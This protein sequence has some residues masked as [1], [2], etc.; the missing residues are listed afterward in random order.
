[1]TDVVLLADIFENFRTTCL[2][3]YKLDPC[4]FLTSP[5]LSW[6]AALKFTKVELELLSDVAMLYFIISCIRGGVSTISTRFSEANNK[7]MTNHDPTKESKF[8]TYLDANNL[9]GSAMSKK[10]PTHGFKWMTDTDLIDWED[11][12]CI[13]EVDLKYPRSLHQLHNLYP[14][15]PE[16]I[17]INKVD[18][19][20]PNLNDKKKYII[21]YEALKLYQSLGLID[22]N[23]DMRT[24]AT[25]NFE[26]DFYKLMNN[27]CYGKTL[28]NVFNRVDVRLVT[29]KEQ[30]SKLINKPNYN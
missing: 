16:S 10:L 2:D 27:S 9:Y 19:L 4:W 28:E 1:M 11:H 12:S 23:T 24:I 29:T 15:A 14:L 26:K 25:T 13:L 20:V 5:S 7:Y 3:A 18:K 21:H 6:T 8:I 17:K 30:A 22:L